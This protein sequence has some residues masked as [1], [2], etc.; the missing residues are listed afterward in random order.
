MSKVTRRMMFR[1]CEPY[2]GAIKRWLSYDDKELLT[3]RFYL[4]A[5][6]LD[7]LR[8][9][10]S[11][12]STVEIAIEHPTA[13]LHVEITPSMDTVYSDGCDDRAFKAASK[14]VEP[15][16]FQVAGLYFQKNVLRAFLSTKGLIKDPR[17]ISVVRAIGVLFRL[18][19]LAGL[20]RLMMVNV[21]GARKSEIP[22][23]VECKA[24]V[25]VLVAALQESLIVT[26]RQKS[27]SKA[28]E[29]ISQANIPAPVET[30]LICEGGEEKS[31]EQGGKGENRGEE[32]E[33]NN[34][35]LSVADSENIIQQSILLNTASKLLQS[36]IEE[37]GDQLKLASWRPRAMATASPRLAR[38]AAL[39][40]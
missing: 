33:Q 28:R 3:N 4:L 7:I 31:E 15:S 9:S 10:D 38:G 29:L 19:H 35:V 40:G 25:L 2:F 26:K 30:S 20:G 11:S 32:P 21:D 34:S 13:D 16:T 17:I 22:I 6:L 14:M 39:T 27:P 37:G 1:N 8:D 12:K 5:Q 23:T 24:D 36:A 18:S